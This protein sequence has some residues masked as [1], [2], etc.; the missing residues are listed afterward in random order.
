MVNTIIPT[1]IATNPERESVTGNANKTAPPETAPTI[2]AQNF[3]FM[4]FS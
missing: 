3:L 1:G 2:N 4:I